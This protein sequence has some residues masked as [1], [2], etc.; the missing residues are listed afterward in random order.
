MALTWEEVARLDPLQL[1]LGGGS[2]CHPDPR[3]P[4]YVSVELRPQTAYSVAH[5][6]TRPI[7]LPDATVQRILSEHFIEHLDEPAIVALLAECHRLLRPGGLARFAVPD[8]AHPR[9]RRCLALGYDPRRRDHVTLP[10]RQNLETLVARSPFRTARFYQY[11]QDDRFIEQPVD[12]GF[13]FV[14]RTP[15]ND[16]RNR[17]DGARRQA[18]RL[19]RD[20]GTWLRYGIYTR[21]IHRDTRRYHRLAVTSVVFDLVKEP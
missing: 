9:D 20:L 19:L 18:G 13:G 15:D 5:D 8:Y 14:Q 4:H 12:Y 17:S 16:P 1:N 10:T 3:Y 21:D 6:L 2:C 11:W 7:P